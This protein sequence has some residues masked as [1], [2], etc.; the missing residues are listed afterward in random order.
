MA[1]GT[2]GVM[3]YIE[4]Q[5][6][7]TRMMRLRFADEYS[8]TVATTLRMVAAMGLGEVSLSA[9]DKLHRIVVSDSWFAL[10]RQP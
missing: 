5:E 10:L 9:S 4:L 6:G 2:S 7:K 8:A 1:D 3:M